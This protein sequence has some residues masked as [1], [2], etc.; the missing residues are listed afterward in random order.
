VSTATCMYTLTKDEH[1]LIDW[2]PHDQVNRAGKDVKDVLM[3]SPCSGHGFKFCSVVG[4][5]CSQLLTTGQSELD[6][7]LFRLR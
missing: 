3:V 7:S 4:E 2:Y 6:I 1:F 5:I